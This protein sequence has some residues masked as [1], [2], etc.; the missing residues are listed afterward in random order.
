MNAVKGKDKRKMK[1]MLTIVKLADVNGGPKFKMDL[2]SPLRIGDPITLKVSLNRQSG[3]R[4]EVLDVQGSFRVESVGFDT[5]I[6]P[7]RQVI[8]VASTT[9]A[10]T[11]RSVKK[12]VSEAPSLGPCRFPP[13]S[14]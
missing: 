7:C 4:S 1:Y 6:G 8:N 10:P 11:W 3:G 2:P 14:I 12:V 13:T 5:S 9:K